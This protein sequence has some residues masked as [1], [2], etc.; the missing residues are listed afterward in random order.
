VKGAARLLLLAGSL[1][2]AC[3]VLELTLMARY[4]AELGEG[5]WRPAPTLG[6]PFLHLA[7]PGRGDMN[8]L[9]IRRRSPTQPAPPRG[10]LRVLSYGDSVAHGYRLRHDETYSHL[11]E[12]RLDRTAPPRVEILNMFRGHSPSVYA[13]HL[14]RDVPMLSPDAVLLEIELLNDVSDEVFVE[15][16][17]VAEDGLP[18]ELRRARYLLGFDGH[19]LP[20]SGGGGAWWQRTLLAGRLRRWWGRQL[21]KRP[22]EAVF[23]EQADVAYYVTRSERHLLTQ[24]STEAAFERLFQSLAGIHHF[25]AEREVGFLLAILPSRD[26]Y[27]QGR[28]AQGASRLLE[29][30]RVRAAELEIPAVTLRDEI[31]RAGGEALYL[32]FCHPTAEGSAAIAEALEAPVRQLLGLPAVAAPPSP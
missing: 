6:S 8:G 10:T 32:D 3:T 21:S 28:F 17:G 16:R 31:G 1:V 20:S 25:L 12:Q 7:A 22:D 19:L 30:A 15:T 18:E 9:S 26:V 27:Q 24:A 13:F 2:L 29:R 4:R 14:R 11:L 5:P 23:G